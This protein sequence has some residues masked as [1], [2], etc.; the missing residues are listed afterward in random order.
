MIECHSSTIM[1]KSKS[2]EISSS[3]KFILNRKLANNCFLLDLLSSSIFLDLKHPVETSTHA[4]ET[5]P[6]LSD[7]APRKLLV[8]LSSKLSSVKVPGEI[9]LTTSLLSG[10]FFDFIFASSDV[11]VCSHTATLKPFLINL[12]K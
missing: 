10:P 11:S 2:S 12:G 4:I 7:I 5:D 8:F 6:L 9:I 1:S 3:E